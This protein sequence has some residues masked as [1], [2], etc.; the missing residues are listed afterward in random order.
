MAL[1]RSSG[2]IEAS[3]YDAED[4]APMLTIK[5]YHR[6]QLGNELQLYVQHG[7]LDNI[8]QKQQMA[9]LGRMMRNDA[10]MSDGSGGSDDSDYASDGL[11]DEDYIL[12][13]DDVVF[14]MNVDRG[15][16]ND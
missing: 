2:K 3:V 9:R 15:V 6:S 10:G 1:S 8:G 5:L 12:E 14:D 7:D 11:I 13:E 4:E 16:Q